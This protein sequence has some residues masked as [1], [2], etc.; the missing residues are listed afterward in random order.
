MLCDNQASLLSNQS[1][2]IHGSR[3]KWKFLSCQQFHPYSYKIVDSRAFISWSLIHGSS[4]SGLIK[5]GPGRLPPMEVNLSPFHAHSW[6]PVYWPGVL[7]GE[8]AQKQ[9]CCLHQ[10]SL[11]ICWHTAWR[12][13]NTDNDSWIFL[14]CS[15]SLLSP[16]LTS[17][18]NTW[19]LH[20]NFHQRTVNAMETWMFLLLLKQF[21]GLY[22]LG[23][24]SIWT[25]I[26]LNLGICMFCWK[27]DFVVNGQ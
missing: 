27:A 2:L 12:W 24:T 21:Y 16:G 1:S 4:W 14:M 15:I 19:K 6:H 22:I 8:T 17:K 3:I 26:M 7:P 5:L 10:T 23:S 11:C 13:Q 20:C 9:E 18:L 25:Q